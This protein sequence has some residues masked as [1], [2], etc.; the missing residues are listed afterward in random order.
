M[1]F[2]YNAALIKSDEPPKPKVNKDNLSVLLKPPNL[3]E[4]IHANLKAENEDELAQFYHKD[5][6]PMVKKEYTYIEDTPVQDP[7]VVK[8]NHI[9]ELL[10]QQKEMKTNQK[11]EEIVLFCFIGLFI[12]YILES[13]VSIGKYSR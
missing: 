8:V 2:A 5:V 10:E 1:A 4:N 11:N 12:I 9:I 6:T 13:F 7:L 3:A